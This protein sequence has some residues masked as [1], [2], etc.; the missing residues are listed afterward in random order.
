MYVNPANRRVV[1]LALT[2][3]LL[4]V[5]VT[6]GSFVTVPYVSVGPG[7]TLNTLAKNGS[8]DVVMI[9]GASTRATDGHLNL[10]TVSVTSKLTLFQALGSWFS[11]RDAVEPREIYFPPDKSPK[12]VRENDLQ[13]MGGSESTATV[14]ALRYLKRPV[15]LSV[16]VDPKGPG[17]K[18][19]RSGDVV[20]AVNGRAVSTPNDLRT[21]ISGLTPG[22]V[23]VVDIV[24][25]GTPMS[26]PVTLGARPDDKSKGYVGV[27]PQFVNADPSLTIDFN[28][29]GIGGPS[30]GLMFT[31]AIIDKLGSVDLTGGKFIAGTGT[32]ADDGD[33]GEIGGI[34]HKMRAARDAGATAFL[35]PAGNCPEALSDKP[36]G[37][38]L[39]K[40]DKLDDAITALA[41]IRGSGT[42]PR[43]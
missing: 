18:A 1:T 9:K 3:V 14:A 30:A 12:E 20:K 16:G 41:A 26:V 15:A 25:A 29:D 43:C 28:V 13:Q 10:T 27:T 34:T 35:V 24:R 17:S 11:G 38:T 36:G 8:K 4:V 19:L 6:V 21:A 5:L 42:A 22:A 37:L 39:Y 40:V 32:M 7:P 2:L 31:L 33:V 23:I